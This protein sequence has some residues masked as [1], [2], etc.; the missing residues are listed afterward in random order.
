MMA[1][2][3]NLS[4]KTLDLLVTPHKCKLPLRLV[5]LERF[6]CTTQGQL[7]SASPLTAPHPLMIQAY[8][9]GQ[10]LIKSRIL[11]TRGIFLYVLCIS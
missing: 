6:L 9:L 3:P 7:L 4:Q 2:W 5:C 10:L 1:I 11:E 8:K